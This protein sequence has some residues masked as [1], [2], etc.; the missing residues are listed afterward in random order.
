MMITPKLI[1]AAIG[2]RAGQ[3]AAGLAVASLIVLLA[4]TA[5]LVAVILAFA[6][7]QESPPV[8]YDDSNDWYEPTRPM[9]VAVREE[10]L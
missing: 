7:A 3:F 2:T 5:L 4:A 9:K 1:D 8:E 10:E 6:E